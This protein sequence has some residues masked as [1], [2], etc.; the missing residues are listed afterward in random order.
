MARATGVLGTDRESG[1]SSCL[2]RLRRGVHSGPRH[3]RAGHESL[4]VG[5]HQL[6]WLAVQSG[7]QFTN[8]AGPRL[9]LAALDAGHGPG[10]DTRPLGKF[11]LSQR[12]LET[13]L[14]K[15]VEVHHGRAR[16]W[17]RASRAEIA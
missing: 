17:Y 7:C 10:A 12:R 3:A 1:K 11:A 13:T 15:P 16:A 2:C 8:G 9:S 6:A 14:A 5:N 4:V